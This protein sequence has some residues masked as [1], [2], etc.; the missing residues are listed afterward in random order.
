MRKSHKKQLPLCQPTPD[1]P[2]A[3]EMTEISKILD[4]N[5]SIYDQVQ[6]IRLD[7]VRY[8]PQSEP[9]VEQARIGL[10][11]AIYYIAKS[12]LMDVMPN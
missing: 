6:R 1:H 9:F 2:K 3:K 12:F 8:E 10:R 11:C 4:Q 7:C 5:Y